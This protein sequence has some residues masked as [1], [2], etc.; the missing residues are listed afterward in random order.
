LTTRL[1]QENH[2]LEFWTTAGIRSSYLV[3]G[4]KVRWILGRLGDP[5]DVIVIPRPEPPGTTTHTPVRAIATVN[6]S[7][8]RAPVVNA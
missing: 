7:T 6:H 3:D 8:A 2:T 5:D 1:E 4:T